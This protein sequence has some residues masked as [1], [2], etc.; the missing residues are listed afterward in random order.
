MKTVR[1]FDAHLAPHGEKDKLFEKVHL[2][3]LDNLPTGKILHQQ[4]PSVKT[5]MD[6]LR[7]LFAT[8][9]RVNCEN[10]KAS[11]ISEN[12]TERTQLQVEFFNEI[13]ETKLEC[14][15]KHVELSNTE[16][17]LEQSGELIQKMTLQHLQKASKASSS[18]QKKPRRDTESDFSEWMAAM[19]ADMAN[20]RRENGKNLNYEGESWICKSRN[21]EVEEQERA[22]K[23]ETEK[24]R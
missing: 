8:Q 14:K 22:H 3:F 4:K 13:T 19:H 12:M 6:K 24:L 1:E 5:L 7:V 9:K 21:L 2:R 15:C 20:N 17:Q 10:E 11:G 23:R 16:T 18:A